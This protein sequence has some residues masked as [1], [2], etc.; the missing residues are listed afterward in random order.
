[1]RRIIALLSAILI[2]VPMSYLGTVLAHSAQDNL[3]N[4]HSA[5]TLD[6]DNNPLNWVF[7]KWGDLSAEGIITT[8]ANDGNVGL[9]VSVTDRTSGD[10]KWFFDPVTVEASEDYVFSDYYKS[11][12]PSETVI[13]FTAGDGAVSYK[14]LGT[15]PVRADWSPTNYSFTTKADTAKLSIFHVM[16]Q[17][18]ELWV[19][20]YSLTEKIPPAE[21]QFA[22][23][24][25]EDPNMVDPTRPQSWTPQHWGQ[26][27]PQFSYLNEGYNDD[28]SVKVEI[29]SYTSG[30]AKW[31]PDFINLVPGQDYRFSNWYKSNI[32]SRF[33]VAMADANGVMSYSELQTA[34]ASSDWALY[35][36]TFKV[37]TS[38]VSISAFHLISSVG[39]L[40]TDNFSIDEY[41]PQGFDRGLLTLTFD[42]GW[43]DNI[44]TALPMMAEYGYLSNQFYATTYIQNS[45]LDNAEEIILDIQSMGHEIGSHSV[46]HPDLTTLYA[47]EVNWEL[48]VSRRYLKSLTGSPINYFA[49]PYGAYNQE[50]KNRIMNY[51]RQS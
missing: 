39:Y 43:E 32:D 25:L 37:P 12:A 3:I 27:S 51:G 35:S 6:A 24:D 47:N 9:H 11:T 41:S 26:N 50:V 49:T 33:V 16:A 31:Y 20:D 19:D 13:Q 7:N 21:G 8:D 30:D 36:D 34:P 2:V 4:N 48:R 15:N 40:I 44:D 29:T 1:M 22:N 38:T 10:A 18:G 23:S 5:E 17:N 45:Y 28:H 14:W 42:D 46:T